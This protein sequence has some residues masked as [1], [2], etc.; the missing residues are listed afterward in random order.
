M[1]I[2]VMT[3]FSEMFDG[4]FV[5]LREWLKYIE[6]NKTLYLPLDFGPLTPFDGVHWQAP[7]ALTVFYKT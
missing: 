2:F 6:K 1:R 5:I 3:T 4:T 7:I